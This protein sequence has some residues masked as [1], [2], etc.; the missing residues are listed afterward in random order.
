M[1]D[2]RWIVTHATE[3]GATRMWWVDEATANW[4]IDR[5]DTSMPEGAVNRPLIFGPLTGRALIWLTPGQSLTVEKSN[6]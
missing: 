3:H 2:E 1:T 4:L 6:G 5:L